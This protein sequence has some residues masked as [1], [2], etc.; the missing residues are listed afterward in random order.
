MLVSGVGLM[1]VCCS[2]CFCVPSSLSEWRRRRRRVSRRGCSHCVLLQE[3]R[4][5][6]EGWRGGG[7]RMHGRV[8]TVA[9]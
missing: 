2:P 9:V 1:G 3:Y 6:K 8:S 5:L 4:G 7:G